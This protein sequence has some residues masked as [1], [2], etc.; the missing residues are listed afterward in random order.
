M[1]VPVRRVR[2]LLLENV[3]PFLGVMLVFSDLP[4]IMAGYNGHIPMMKNPAA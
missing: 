4:A 2:D 1:A 3:S